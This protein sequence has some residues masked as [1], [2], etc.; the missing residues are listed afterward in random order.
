MAAAPACGWRIPETPASG[1]QCDVDHVR[2]SEP[3]PLKITSP[4]IIHLPEKA[5]PFIV[6][7]VSGDCNIEASFSSRQAVIDATASWEEWPHG[8]VTGPFDADV[9]ETAE[10]LRITATSDSV[11]EIMGI[12]S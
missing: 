8:P 2:E 4:A 1:A 3:N 5:G 10:A 9:L 11:V 12:R 6:K 7:V